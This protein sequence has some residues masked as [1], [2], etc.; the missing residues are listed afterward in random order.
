MTFLL[1]NKLNKNKKVFNSNLYMAIIWQNRL[2]FI[3]VFVLLIGISAIYVALI[4]RPVP[5]LLVDEEGRYI[6]E[7]NYIDE[8]PV[9]YVQ[10]ESM[11]KR[12]IQHYMSQNSVTIY[13]DSEIALAAVCPQLGNEMR[14]EWVEGG[15]LARVVQRLQV[16][17]VVFNDFQVLKYINSK[18]IQV[19]IKGNIIVGGEQYSDTASDFIIELSL[20]LVPLT[21]R[22]HL[23]I[24]VCSVRFL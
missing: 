11:T 3:L 16:S 20:K 4:I 6:A 9:N 1:H 10:L 13:E 18:D 15:K 8:P 7:V 23:G 12:F 22:N 21:Q 2:L 14:K 5:L 17:R 19:L 24:E